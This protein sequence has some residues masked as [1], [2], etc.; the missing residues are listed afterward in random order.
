M[1]TNSEHIIL[2]YIALFSYIA[3]YIY[4]VKLRKS[5]T[6]DFNNKNQNDAR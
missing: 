6:C 1:C 3:S 5:V 4:L 2:Q